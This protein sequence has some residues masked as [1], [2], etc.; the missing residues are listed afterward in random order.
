MARSERPR[1]RR[2]LRK[3][4]SAEMTSATDLV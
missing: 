3:A 1:S 4:R 2:P